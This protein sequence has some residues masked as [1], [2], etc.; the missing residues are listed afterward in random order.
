MKRSTLISIAI[1]VLI[2]IAISLYKSV[3]SLSTIS[4]SPS[5]P[6]EDAPVV[7][8]EL[9]ERYTNDK[10]AF[11]FS[12]PKGYTVRLMQDPER[13][14]ASVI[15]VQ[16]ASTSVG[17]QIHIEST[18]EG[19]TELTKERIQTDLPGM[20]IKDPQEVVMGDDKN[21]GKGI[22]FLSDDAAFGGNSREVWFVFNRNLYQI[23]T[24][25]KYDPLLQAVLTSWKFD[26][27]KK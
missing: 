21:A 11:S 22:A 1:V 5:A 7:V 17:F 18:G 4:N 6:S 8:G 27:T 19:F 12:Y 16:N 20:L 26:L 14:N 10:Y 25:A 15:L 13:D 23:R 24:Y 3:T 9:S 2:L